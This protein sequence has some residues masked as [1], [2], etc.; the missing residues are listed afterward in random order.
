MASDHGVPDIGRIGLVLPTG[1]GLVSPTGTTAANRV[2]GGAAPGT[3]PMLAELARH[4]ERSGFDALWVEDGTHH[5]LEACSVL[6]ALAMVVDRS[7]LGVLVAD[8]FRRH[9]SILAKQVTTVDVLA[10]GRAVLGIAPP[11]GP[12]GRFAEVLQVVRAVFT[13][14]A[15]TWTGR[16]YRLAGAANRPPPA[17]P[18]G[19]P[20]LAGP[21]HVAP[22]PIG[23]GPAGRPGD[24][25]DGGS[26]SGD[27]G[28]EQAA[29][30][31]DGVIFAGGVHAVARAVDRLS[32]WCRQVGRDASE[33]TLLWVGEVDVAP[34]LGT[35]L[36]SLID[37]GIQGLA[38][39]IGPRHA[40]GPGGS[41]PAVL[42]PHPDDVTAVADVLRGIVGSGAWPDGGQA[43]ATD[44]PTASPPGLP[45]HGT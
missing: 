2:G 42:F 7:S 5:V 8:P 16:W 45:G 43:R 11:A 9:P 37:V 19:C 20:V 27:V 14:D 18:G 28:L 39:R 21:V 38:V 29:R 25:G 33:L 26:P 32:R 13:V 1:I 4:A 31:A 30:Y 22:D 12:I 15:P 34:S 23:V 35:K 44:R 10:G 6:G 36:R 40:S 3:F 17:R 41:S 24:G